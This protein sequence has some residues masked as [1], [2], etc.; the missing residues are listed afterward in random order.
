[1]EEVEGLSP[2]ISTTL[3]PLKEASKCWPL[4]LLQLLGLFQYNHDCVTV[5]IACGY[6]VRVICIIQIDTRQLSL[7]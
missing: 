5:M 7:A 3:N 4:Y 1:M 6:F 2:S